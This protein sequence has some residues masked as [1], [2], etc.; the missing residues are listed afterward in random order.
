MGKI[1]GEEEWEKGDKGKGRGIEVR[2]ENEKK[3]RESKRIRGNKRRKEER[4]EEEMMEERERKEEIMEGR[5]RK[6]ERKGDNGRK[7]GLRD[8]R[9]R[10]KKKPNKLCQRNY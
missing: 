3:G 8:M 10:G 6:R 4:R 7:R 9:V 2:E 1:R 5:E